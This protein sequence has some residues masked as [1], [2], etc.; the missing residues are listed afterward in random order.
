MYVDYFQEEK[1][2]SPLEKEKESP[3][4]IDDVKKESSVGKDEVL[5]SGKSTISTVEDDGRTEN[6]VSSL[7]DTEMTPR[8][9]PRALGILEGFI[10]ETVV[11]LAADVRKDSRVEHYVGEIMKDLLKEAVHECLVVQNQG[12][13]NLG[14]CQTFCRCPYALVNGVG[15]VG[16]GGP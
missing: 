4:K 14:S 5:E 16:V 1:V 3:S 13:V 10:E 6:D 2:R 9:T 7:T 11:D 12:K 8:R 15:R